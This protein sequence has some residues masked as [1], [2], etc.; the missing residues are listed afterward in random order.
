MSE[1]GPAWAH[2]LHLD[3]VQVTVV[4]NSEICPHGCSGIITPSVPRYKPWS[5]GLTVRLNIVKLMQG[6]RIYYKER[7]IH[8]ILNIQREDGSFVEVTAIL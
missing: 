1:F 8:N 4:A 2:I 6:F 5:S 7:M 3:T